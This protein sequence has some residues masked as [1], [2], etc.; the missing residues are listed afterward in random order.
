[1]SG[2]TCQL[3]F[4][5]HESECLL[6]L[7]TRG[8]LTF[9]EPNT[10]LRLSLFGQVLE[11]SWAGQYGRRANQVLAAKLLVSY[12]RSFMSCH[13]LFIHNGPMDVCH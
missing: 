8:D 3:L 2:R 13:L 5:Q 11:G 4:T 12:V 1:M 9:L 10:N 6:C 7:V